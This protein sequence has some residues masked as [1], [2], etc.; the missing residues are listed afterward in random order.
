MRNILFAFASA[1]TVF[2]THPAFA[3]ETMSLEEAG[4]ALP[5]A[6]AAMQPTALPQ[7]KPFVV[8]ISWANFIDNGSS[9]AASLA[10]VEPATGEESPVLDNGFSLS[11]GDEAKN[12]EIKPF[13]L[14][15]AYKTKNNISVRTKRSG[16]M[17][18]KKIKFEPACVPAMPPSKTDIDKPEFSE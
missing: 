6:A 7:Q 1:A 18:F 5:A 9:G 4:I 15:F 3:V 16:V 17:L 10:K 8:N 13:K 12:N 11:L 14:E 2:L